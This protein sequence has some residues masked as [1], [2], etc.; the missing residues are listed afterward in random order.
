M[1]VPS[2]QARG[3]PVVPQRGTPASATETTLRIGLIAPG[4]LD[5]TGRRDVI[6]ALLSLTERL[7]RNHRVTV[8]VVRQE[9][10]PSRFS[11]LG[12]DVV[13][14]GYMTAARPGRVSLR[15]LFRML[16]AL[17]RD[18]WS[19]DVLHAFW[20]AECGVLAAL[21]GQ[22]WRVP[23]VVSVG[24]GEL[25]WVPQVAYG[26]RGDWQCRAQSAIALWCAA[27][28]TAG[29][30]YARRPLAGHRSVTRIV[31]L[32]VD[33]A[34]FHGPL[35]RP[36]GP[37]WRLLHVASLNR[38]KNQGM[39]L[40][41]VQLVQDQLL[42]VRLDIV[43]EDFLDSAL[44]EMA[45]ELGLSE[46][47]HFHGPLDHEAI[48]PLYRQAHLYLQAS[49]HESQGVAVCEAAACGVP[50][51]GTA[52]G[53]VADLAPA[54]AY[55]VPADDAAAM[56]TAILTLLGDRPQRERL[57][58][59]AQAWARAHDAD[60]TAATFAAL[61]RQLAAR[62]TATATVRSGRAGAA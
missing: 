45:A 61:Y 37:P 26:G 28:V 41:A 4:G 12:A 34:R 59:A 48:V 25:V 32:G 36:D 16:V 38:V 52:V 17:G 54:A 50:T 8:V 47:V 55:I 2:L 23:V 51:V 6:P 60:W 56:A 46:V 31:P 21:A 5:R 44:Q 18:G 49:W 58:R 22:L 19:F 24:G 62:R 3:T 10:E 40:R 7:S 30:H 13:N 27:A 9:P 57:G 33:T 20:I 53:L 43:G 42:G 29:S 39:L 15:C 35:E 11:L 1:R 14:L